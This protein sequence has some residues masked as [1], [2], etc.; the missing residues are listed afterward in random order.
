MPD[1]RFFDSLGPV[2]LGELADLSGATLLR[3]DRATLVGV[4][5]PLGQAG[6]DAVSFLSDRRYAADAH[7][8]RAAAC[9][10]PAGGA[11]AVPASCAVLTTRSPQGAWAVAA[12][13]LHQPR[14]S[15]ATDR[16]VHPTAELE[17]GVQLSRGVVIEAGARVGRGTSIGAGAVIGVGVAIGRDCRIGAR[18]VVEFALIGDRVTLL[19]GAVIGQAGFGAALGPTGLIDVPQLGRVILQD[20]VTIGAVACVDRGAWGDTVVGENTKIDNMVQVGHNVQIGR[21]CA[22]AAQVGISG[23]VVIGDGVQIGGQ[24]GIADHAVIGDGASIAAQAGITKG[25]PAGQVWAGYPARPSR[26]WAREAAW[27]TLRAARKPRGDKEG[28]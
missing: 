7:A 15:S 3:G 4:A 1:P 17:E 8:T 22:L 9:F 20:G 28:E 14:Q 2:S 13:R 19:A 5:A 16:L 11:D 24:V 23:S 26:Q 25:V 10:L 12:G 18:A 6:P 27:V 21:N